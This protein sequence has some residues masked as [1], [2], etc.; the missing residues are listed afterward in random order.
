MIKRLNNSRTRSLLANL[1]SFPSSLV[2]TSNFASSS[3]LVSRIS[4]YYYYRYYGWISE[5]PNPTTTTTERK[6]PAKCIPVLQ[7]SLLMRHRLD[8]LSYPI[9]L[10]LPSAIQSWNRWNWLLYWKPLPYSF[11]VFWAI[12]WMRRKMQTRSVGYYPC[13]RTTIYIRWE[14]HPLRIYLQ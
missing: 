7:W 12:L 11:V 1:P 4:Y 14:F 8:Y 10:L 9:L 3:N 13:W 6:Q 2:P 5:K